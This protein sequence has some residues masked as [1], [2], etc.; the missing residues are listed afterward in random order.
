MADTRN[1][2]RIIVPQ[3]VVSGGLGA[4]IPEE[5]SAVDNLLHT[6]FW[7]ILSSIFFLADSKFEIDPYDVELHGLMSP[8][9]Y[10]EAIENLNEKMRKSRAGMVDGVLLA[11]G[12]LV[13]V[14]MVIWGVRH[15]SRTKKRKKLLK[16]GIHDFNTRYPELMMRWNR[17]PQS[18]LTIEV[19]PPS[20]TNYNAEVAHEME[21]GFISD[22]TGD[23]NH[24]PLQQFVPQQQTQAATMQQ[25][26]PGLL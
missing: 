3:R 24:Q 14:P 6:I 4:C 20:D 7:L 13:M 11:T 19:R 25:Q 21:S 8:D 15:R 16:E 23:M 18:S 10:T 26:P 1:R 9:Q 12:A 5:I 17:R 2:L 22:T